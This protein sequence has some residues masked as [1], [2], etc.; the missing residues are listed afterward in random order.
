[1]TYLYLPKSARAY[2]F[3]KLTKTNDYF[4]SDPVSADPICPQPSMTYIYIYTYIY[5][6]QDPRE[7]NAGSG[8]SIVSALGAAG[9]LRISNML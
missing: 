2:L 7:V 1:M 3:P 8:A 4:C 5:L 6:T 9:Y